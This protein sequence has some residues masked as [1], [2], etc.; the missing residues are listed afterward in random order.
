VSVFAL[1]DDLAAGSAFESIANE[2]AV[3]QA[4]I[5]AAIPFAAQL[6]ATAVGLMELLNAP[7]C[8]V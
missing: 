7:H 1:R 8:P 3:T 2:Y 5:R 4:D 6:L